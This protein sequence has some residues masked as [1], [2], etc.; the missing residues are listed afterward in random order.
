MKRW[1]WLTAKNREHIAD[2]FTY[3]SNGG[4]MGMVSASTYL[5][6][7]ANSP[8]IVLLLRPWNE[9]EDE[10]LLR[11]E[12][13]IIGGAR[14]GRRSRRSR[15]ARHILLNSSS[16]TFPGNKNHICRSNST[17][18][19]V[20]NIRM[21]RNI[22]IR[23]SSCSLWKNS[24]TDNNEIRFAITWIIPI[25]SP[26]RGICPPLAIVVGNCVDCWSIL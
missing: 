19:P 26:W 25:C 21:E 6:T 8:W 23:S 7:Y 20:I 1:S 10:G 14:K 4:W 3:L 2:N 18:L 22:P 5:S 16:Y 9:H 13:G 24:S 11:D 17:T 12:S 15:F